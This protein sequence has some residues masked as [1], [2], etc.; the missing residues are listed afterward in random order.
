MTTLAIPQ[1]RTLD[2]L[3]VIG[4]S[5]LLALSAY[6]IIPLPFSPVP[7][8]L[9][10][11]V[12]VLLGI[13]LGPKKGALAVGLYFLEGICGLPVFMGGSAS[14]LHFLTPTGGYLLGFLP[15]AYLAGHLSRRL[16]AL[17]AL[18]L[19]HLPLYL[20]GTAYLATFIGLTN[21]LLL[22]VVPFL[23]GCLLK[24]LAFATWVSK[25]NAANLR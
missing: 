16:S 17:P 14:L 10:P 19:G 25:R 4:G 1:T 20:F 18:L 12:A 23:P 3:Q 24:S 15:S 22:G 11:T 9:H 2:A 5:I 21:A 7:I 6:L 8:A 13:M